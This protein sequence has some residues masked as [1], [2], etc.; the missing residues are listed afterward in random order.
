M[1]EIIAAATA[2]LY[3]LLITRRSWVAWPVYIISSLLYAPVFWSAN[4]YGDAVL[5]LYFV[6]VGFYAW[7]RWGRA[8]GP[9][10]VERWRLKRHLWILVSWVLAAIMLG[11]LLSSTPAG[12][13]GYGDALVTVGSVV[14][15]VLT[16]RGVLENWIYW[17]VI[18]VIATLLFGVRS[19]VATMWLYSLYTILAVRGLYVW[20]SALRYP[21]SR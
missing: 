20:K 15:T 4:L 9:V 2:V 18:D 5:Q 17:I 1:L 16:A 21:D 13:L 14:A 10:A 11:R 3:L 8:E 6:S 7:W 19:L 12:A